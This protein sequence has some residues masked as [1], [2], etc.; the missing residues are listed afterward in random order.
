MLFLLAAGQTIGEKP[1]EE[2]LS[3]TTVFKRKEIN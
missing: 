2:I 1:F 3:K